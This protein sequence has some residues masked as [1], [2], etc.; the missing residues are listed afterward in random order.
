MGF[1]VSL[2]KVGDVVVIRMAGRI[3]A[4]EEMDS[5]RGNICTLTEND[6][7][8]I[9]LHLGGVEYVD[10]DGVA[11]FVELFGLVK[12][13]RGVL[14]LTNLTDSIL[15][16]LS[17]TRVAEIFEIFDDEVTAVASFAEK[18]VWA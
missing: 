11:M 18:K 6:F 10:S 14:K 15:C 2:R 16:A 9:L 1:T 3:T 13:V 8:K 17:A 4:G 7:R 5:F 12:F